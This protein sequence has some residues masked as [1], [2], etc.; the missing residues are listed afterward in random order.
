MGRRQ[1]PDAASGEDAVVDA[2]TDGFDFLG[3]RFEGRKHWPRNKS[4]AKF[5]D[6][7]RSKTRRTS[8]ESLPS[9]IASVNRTLRGWFAYF[10]HSSRVDLPKPR[11]LDPNASAQPSATPTRRSRP[12]SSGWTIHAGPTPS[13]PS[14]GCSVW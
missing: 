2:R 8:G 10:Q 4:L 7:I 6:A 5:K 3:Y 12:G 1:R 11:R 14:R 9:I 13:S